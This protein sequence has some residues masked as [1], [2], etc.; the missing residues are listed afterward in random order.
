MEIEYF[1]HP[2][3]R[4]GS[5]PLAARAGDFIFVGGQMAVHPT[6]GVPA[7]VTGTP[8]RPFHGSGMERQINYIYSNLSHTLSELG[9]S[10]R[11]IMK[12][13]SYHI[14]GDEVDMA[15]RLRKDF[16]G[17]EAPPPSTLVMIPETTVP[18]AT[19]VLDVTT[20]ANASVRPRSIVLQPRAQQHSDY[21]PVPLRSLYGWP[22]FSQASR[23]GGFI[24]TVGVGGREL[25][26]EH[27]ETLPRLDER[28]HEYAQ[29]LPQPKFPYE[30]N[31]MAM[32]TEWILTGLKGVLEAAGTS[33]EHVVR[34]EIHL[35]HMKHLTALN[36][37]WERFFP[38][39]PPAR[40]IVPL[41]LARPDIML[42]EIELIAVD[43]E[44]PYRKEII[45]TTDAPTPLGPEPQAVRAGPYV[46]LS[47]QLATDFKHG[48][49][50]EAQPDVAFPFHSSGIV[51]EVRYIYKNV[52]SILRAAGTSPTNLVKRRAVHL[53]LGDLTDAEECW[54]EKLFD[55][56]PPTTVFRVEGPLA[57]PGC[58]VQYDLT[59]YI[60][61][62]QR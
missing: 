6:Q 20:L 1:R 49:A 38:V 45:G 57:V 37:V 54:R 25:D 27:P 36:K 53:H 60:P 30:H 39:D 21:K 12:I 14:N 13:N 33:L 59:G 44:G 17:V 2:D 51:R 56:L 16:F 29:P 8:G 23:G 61:D 40:V 24:F 52:E 62:W 55:R 42:V 22:V 58:T 7:E 3:A 46:Y 41:A 28:T 32:Q 19:V 5:A 4:P 31:R 9:S 11:Q 35:S 48:L 18:G 34:A 26:E 15:L 50:H 10:I 47:T 43:P